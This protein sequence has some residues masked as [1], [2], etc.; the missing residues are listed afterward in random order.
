MNLIHR[1]LSNIL[2]F[3]LGTIVVIG[4]VFVFSNFWT[5]TASISDAFQGKNA[6]LLNA[7]LLVTK[8]SQW[9]SLVAETD[10]VSSQNQSFYISFLYNSSQDTSKRLLQSPYSHSLSLQDGKWTIVI[11]FDN[12][13]I[14]R[15]SK[16]FDFITP[17]QD[18]VDMPL[19]DSIIWHDS[20]QLQPLEFDSIDTNSNR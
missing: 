16:I 11:S 10:F 18:L 2:A 7:P 1:I 6:S 20:L 4:L 5:S 15:D 13:K 19:I 8:N 17:V 14:S 3:S 9:L 12:K